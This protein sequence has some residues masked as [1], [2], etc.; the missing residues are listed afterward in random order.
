M[1]IFLVFD[2]I[3]LI[4]DIIFYDIISYLLRDYQFPCKLFI[5]DNFLFLNQFIPLFYIFLHISLIGSKSLFA[6]A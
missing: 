6:I 1:T 5:V 4:Y 2:K 3:V